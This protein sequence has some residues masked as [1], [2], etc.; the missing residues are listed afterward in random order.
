MGHLIE[1]CPRDPNLRSK[2]DTEDDY[3]R[4]QKIK[5]YRKLNADTVVTTTH[6]LKKCI[7]VPSRQSE[8]EEKAYQEHP[9]KRGSM[10]FDDF[11][12]DVFNPYI[13]VEEKKIKD[14][15]GRL[16]KAPTARSRDQSELKTDDKGEKEIVAV[17]EEEPGLSVQAL[18]AQN[19]AKYEFQSISVKS[20]K[21]DQSDGGKG[22][23]LDLSKG[24]R[25]PDKTVQKA[26]ADQDGPDGE[27]ADSP[28]KPEAGDLA[29]DTAP[30]PDATQREP[31]DEE[32][33]EL[34]QSA[35][36]LETEENELQIYYEPEEIEANR[37]KQKRDQFADL[38]HMRA[39][40]AEPQR[41]KF[42]IIEHLHSLDK[43]DEKIKKKKKDKKKK[44]Q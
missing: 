38:I 44:I 33:G 7:I 23:S 29:H 42:N 1:N 34:D 25:A 2:T 4:I 35:E 10:K 9:F 32:E 15:K 41:S 27:N 36:M 6:F 30:T 19:L 28:E 22:D 20:P 5:D 39:A 40:A 43:P 14:E 18:E 13:L 16:V 3:L 17:P 26:A 12:Y 24:G 11:N 21:E 31:H 8:Q 37:Q